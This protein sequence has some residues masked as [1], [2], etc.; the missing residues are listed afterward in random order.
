MVI[1]LAFAVIFLGIAY[2]NT[3]NN[4][5]L[6]PMAIYAICAC[7]YFMHDLKQKRRIY[8]GKLPYPDQEIITHGDSH[9]HFRIL[10]TEDKKGSEI[11]QCHC[12]DV[13]GEFL[14]PHQGGGQNG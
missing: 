11:S 8:Q 5:L 6:L 7:I 4:A 2:F 12:P 13:G 3:H 1:A 10:G 9:Y 14:Y